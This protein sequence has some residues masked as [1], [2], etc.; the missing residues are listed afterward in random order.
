M[1]STGLCTNRHKRLN[2]NALPPPVA[3]SRGGLFS[4]ISQFLSKAFNRRRRHFALDRRA[5]RIADK[6]GLCKTYKEARRKGL[7]P[8]DA[9][10]DWDMFLDEEV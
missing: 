4:R 8:Q 9:L 3:K 1:E 5:M 2:T 10:E 7:S 6:Y